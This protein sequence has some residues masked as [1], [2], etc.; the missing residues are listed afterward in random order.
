MESAAIMSSCHA[1]RDAGRHTGR[2]FCPG[3]GLRVIALKGPSA[4]WCVALCRSK[5]R[6]RG[7]YVWHH[8]GS[9]RDG[10]DGLSSW[11]F[12]KRSRPSR[13]FLG[14]CRK[15]KQVAASR[16]T[17]RNAHDEFIYFGFDF[18]TVRVLPKEILH[19]TPRIHTAG[20]RARLIATVH[21]I[22][23]TQCQHLLKK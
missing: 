11:R 10:T 5:A 14:L 6:T 23:R 22:K 12:G 2:G 21:G 7:I 13:S 16:L 17:R 9:F 20:H 1:E 4:A 19:G 18:P 3:H 15:R 8:K